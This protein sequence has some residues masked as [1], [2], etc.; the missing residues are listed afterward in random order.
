VLVGVLAAVGVAQEQDFKQR[1]VTALVVQADHF[2]AGDDVLR[3]QWWQEQT[4]YA[5][6]SWRVARGT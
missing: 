3:R 6:V 4:T 2:R 5:Y 1:R